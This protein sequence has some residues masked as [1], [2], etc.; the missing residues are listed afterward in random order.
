MEVKDCNDKHCPT[1]GQISLRGRAFRG[2]VVSASAHKTVT[3]EWIRPHYISKYER[4]EKRKTKIKAHNPGCVGAKVG[5]MVEIKES[6]PI[7][8]TKNFVVVK[9]EK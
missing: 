1:H 9:V 2:K 6:R 3:V 8:K 5:D 7:S 4:Y